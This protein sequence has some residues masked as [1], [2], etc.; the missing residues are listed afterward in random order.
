MNAR[1]NA[2]LTFNSNVGEKVRLTIPRAD[3]T[4][5]EARAREAME[6]IIEGGIVITGN[7]IPTGIHGAELV[8]TSRAPLVTA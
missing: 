7:G 4:L 5:T 6:D 2:I 8:T 3:T 1:V